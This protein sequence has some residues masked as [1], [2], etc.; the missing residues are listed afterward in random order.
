MA[1]YMVQKMS[2]GKLPATTYYRKQSAHPS[3]EETGAFTA[4]AIT[5]Y[6]TAHGISEDEVEKGKYFSN[7]GEPA[8]ADAEE[9]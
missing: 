1:K 6:A 7:Q 8:D 9:I 4:A 2:S 3:H 5:A